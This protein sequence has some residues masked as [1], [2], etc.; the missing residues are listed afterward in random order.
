MVCTGSSRSDFLK[1]GASAGVALGLGELG[2]TGLLVRAAVDKGGIA[3]W[4]ETLRLG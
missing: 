3:A 2:L 1:M 4:D